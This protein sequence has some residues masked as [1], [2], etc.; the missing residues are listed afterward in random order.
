ME[1]IY[2]TLCLEDQAMINAIV[3]RV[4]E[5]LSKDSGI[6]LDLLMATLEQL[7]EVKKNTKAKILEEQKLKEAE[8]VK[9]AKEIGK[10]YVDTLKVGDLVTFKYGI[11]NMNIATLPLIKKSAATVQVKYTPEMLSPGTTTLIRNIRFDKIIVPEEFS[12]TFVA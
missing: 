2:D 5:N 12:K 8:N 1:K 11:K 4:K 10:A 6:D 9:I 3:D 7:N